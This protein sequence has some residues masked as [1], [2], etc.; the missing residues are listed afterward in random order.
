MGSST[1]PDEQRPTGAE[2]A[3]YLWRSHTD[4][5]GFTDSCWEHIADDVLPLFGNE[6]PATKEREI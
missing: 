4:H 3:A 5:A 6:G 2:L 1:G